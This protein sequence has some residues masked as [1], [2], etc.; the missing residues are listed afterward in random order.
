MVAADYEGQAHLSFIPQTDPV[1]YNVIARMSSEQAASAA[2]A[3]LHVAGVAG[4]DA[5]VLGTSADAVHTG[6]GLTDLDERLIRGVLRDAGEGAVAGG[7]C[8]GVV[9]LLL[10]ALPPLAGN[11]AAGGH[12]LA[13]AFGVAIGLVAGGLVGG[14]AGFDR[15][16]AGSDTYGDQLAEEPC[17]VGVRV[18]DAAKQLEV[19]ELLRRSG[20][21]G[22][23][24]FAD[25]E[26]PSL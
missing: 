15:S 20:A 12:L 17:I 3:A 16:Q 7:L 5:A 19:C 21:F 4:A 18:A 24:A 22:L 14:V 2:L 26:E 23:R 11:V 13:A 8:G 25:G 1:R 6:T 9:G 10:S